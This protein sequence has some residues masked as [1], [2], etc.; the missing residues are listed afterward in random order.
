[1]V[2]NP[3]VFTGI[4]SAFF[5]GLPSLLSRF[6]GSLLGRSWFLAQ[7]DNSVANPQQQALDRRN[8]YRTDL[9]RR[10]EQAVLQS[11]GDVQGIV[12]NLAQDIPMVMRASPG[13]SLDDLL[14]AL[15]P[16][17]LYGHETPK[18]LRSQL[19]A[20][21]Q[22]WPDPWGWVL[23][24]WAAIISQLLLS[25]GVLSLGQIRTWAEAIG[26]PE[27][28]E[29]LNRGQSLTQLRAQVKAQPCPA[30]TI[31]LYCFG[32][33]PDA[34]TLTLAR[35]QQ[36]SPAAEALALTLSGAY[37]GWADLPER[38][39]RPDDPTVLTGLTFAQ[40]LW[41]HWLGV[42]LPPAHA[43]PLEAFGAAQTLQPRS[44]QVLISLVDP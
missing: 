37:R 11:Q 14:L 38:I 18:R 26:H 1:M 22:A 35:A 12:H 2:L 25:Q 6:Q 8:L 23:Q 43:S 9:Y 24:G 13:A 31:A 28:C 41:Q 40:Q 17:I 33:T 34:P 3:V 10:V 39:S 19:Q 44:G 27:I 21:S 16:L 7:R 32:T 30:L 4:T 5:L 29:G 36:Y 20:L 42:Y 15:V